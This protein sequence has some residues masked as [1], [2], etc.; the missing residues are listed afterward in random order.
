M[1]NIVV[2]STPYEI[3]VTNSPANIVVSDALTNQQLVNVSVSNSIVNV[4]STPSNIIVSATA[5][6]GNTTIRNAIS[7]SNVSGFG[8]LTYSNVTGVIGHVGV[9][10]A[11]IQTYSKLGLSNTSPILY[12]NVTGVIGIDTDLVFSNALANA[13]FTTQTTDNLTEGSTNLYYSDARVD[14]RV[15]TTILNNAIVLKEYSETVVANG[16]QSGNVTLAMTSGSIHTL[17]ATGNITNIDLTSIV[18]GATATIIVE[19]DVFGNHT[20]ITSSQFTNWNFMG[21]ITDLGPIPLSR[22]IIVVNYADGIYNASIATPDQAT[23]DDLA[24]GITNLYFDQSGNNTTTGNISA[25]YF[26]GDGSQLTNISTLTNADVV[27]HI[28]TVPLA[29]G[30]N[31]T[32]NGDAIVTGNLEVTGNINYREVE[33][34]LVRDQTI[35]LNFGNATAQDAQIIVDRQGSALANVDLKWNETADRWQFSNDGSTYNNMLTSADLPADAVTSVNTQTGVVVLD[36]DDI[37]EGTAKYYATSL[38][39]T[40]FATKTTTDLTE[41]TNL[42]YTQS[43]FDTAFTAKD[44]DDLSEGTTNLYFTTPRQRAGFT[45]T[46]ATASGDGALVYNDATG[47]FTFT[48]AD[49][50]AIDYGDANVVTLLG[51]YTDAISSTANITTTANISGNYL[52]GNINATSG[53]FGDINYINLPRSGS[54]I[55]TDGKRGTAYIQPV[56]WSGTAYTPLTVPVPDVGGTRKSQTGIKVF[57]P[58]HNAGHD[59]ELSGNLLPIITMHNEDTVSAISEVATWGLYYQWSNSS[60]TGNLVV[61]QYS[62]GTSN[63][64][65]KFVVDSQSEFIG[66]LTVAAETIGS[67]IGDGGNIIAAGNVIAGIDVIATGN[68]SGAYI[69]G[70]GSQLTNIP[71]PADAVTSVNGEVGVVVLD[72]DDIAEGSANLYYTDARVETKIDSYVVGS[73]NI[74]VTSGAI[75]TT[76]ALGNINSITTEASS[77]FTLDSNDGI[78][79]K[80]QFIG[81]TTPVVSITGDGYA[82]FG[83]AEYPLAPRVT[84]SGTTDLK[85]FEFEGTVTLGSPDI[86]IANIQEGPSA[87]AATIGDL[88]VGYTQQGNVNIFPPEAYITA[89]NP[90]AGTVTMSENAINNSTFVYASGQTFDPAVIDTTTGLVISLIS[91]KKANGGSYTSIASQF[92]RKPG[93]YGYPQRGPVASDFDVYAI[94][95]SADY[96]FAD[97]SDFTVARTSFTAANTVI[98]APLG[99]TIGENTDLTNRG[100]NDIFDSFGLNIMWDGLTTKPASSRV[101]TGILLKSYGDNSQIATNPPAGG[102]RLFFTS[103]SGNSNDNPYASYPFQNQELGRLSYWGTNSQTLGPSSYNVPAYTSV[104]AADNWNQWGGGVA[105]NTN[106]FSAATSNG[107]NADTYLA[108]KEGELFLGS[109]STKPITL[110]P[111]SQTTGFSPQNAYSGLFTTW[112]NVHY[113]NPGASTGAKVSVTNGGSVGVGNVGDME[114]S[115]KRVDNS[116]QVTASVTTLFASNFIPD[117]KPLP[118]DW[119]LA[120]L[121]YGNQSFSGKSVTF[122]APSTISASSTGN[123]TALGNNTY[124]FQFA[125][126]GST[127]DVY[128]MIG[129][130]GVV[131]YTSIGGSAAGAFAPQSLG[132]TGT[133]TITSG[134]TDKEWKF[135]LAEQSNDLTLTDDGTVKVTFSD[136]AVTIPNDV[137]IA[138]TYKIT[139]GEFGYNASVTPAGAD[140]VYTLPLNTTEGAGTI[141]QNMSISA[142]GNI[143]VAQAQVMQFAVFAQIQ[144]SDS[145]DQTIDMWYSNNG[146]DIVGSNHQYTIAKQLAG[147]PTKA[148]RFF[149]HIIDCAAGDVIQVHYAVSS[150]NLTF[151]A[152]AAQ[153]TPFV[154]PSGNSISIT[155]IPVGA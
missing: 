5:S 50:G 99:I 68:V 111:A 146:T 20:L 65:Y 75:A 61:G 31:I 96:T 82:L 112:A 36:T 25:S 88:N 41:G 108:Y 147:V 122:S 62:S 81:V 136:S 126:P 102:P 67:G 44:T 124:T 63:N 10:T 119:I 128:Y 12:D 33:D 145:S 42:Y 80:Q 101:Q 45:V 127:G 129:G 71:H 78:V 103:A 19:Q 155:V 57:M 97:V 48:P 105:G 106:V 95:T 92:N 23:T 30:G 51:S 49:L 64:N 116:S 69:L 148:G 133:Y 53:G 34:L 123:E 154:R 39:N 132:A 22:S 28:A 17:T 137:R 14:A 83:A 79:F 38:F 58:E 138:P 76:N 150:T 66:D 110:A 70:D 43:R 52:L 47:V 6:V 4:S 100:E 54:S 74:T 139:S 7:V 24:E 18:D 109:N 113:A 85:Y 77:G 144:N 130:A 32:V 9:S 16:N 93:A 35:T 143:T 21:G 56:P 40:D 120:V 46:T 149:D 142:T 131:T 135:N 140:T 84:Y 90:G 60:I 8:G 72:T 2:T 59:A 141:T 89:I 153:T 73:E 87:N 151:T 107:V 98:K 1:A 118:L 114:L 134:V 86:A 3:A 11:E 115:V 55:L 37:A 125:F 29:V 15:P 94:D 26:L 13:W 117:P 152:Q 121:P 91:D 104:Q 27:A